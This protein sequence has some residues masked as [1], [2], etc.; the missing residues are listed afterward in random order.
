MG[1][2]PSDEMMT[3]LEK[4]C[5]CPPSHAKR[6]VDIMIALRTQRS[7]CNLFLGENSFITPRDLLR[8]AERE[9]SS[10]QELAE[11]GYM[12]LAERLRSEDEKELVQSI[13]ETNLKVKLN[14]NEKYYG[15]DSEARKLLTE[16]AQQLKQASNPL[17]ESIAATKTL[18]R[19]IS[20]VLRCINQKEPVLLV[21]GKYT[22]PYVGWT[23]FVF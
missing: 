6:L 14:M 3:I 18:L 1:D 15:S 4:R 23:S 16:A 7:K 19:L 2:I 22:I 20:L 13:L 12:L 17:V 5:A 21:G 8:W 10:K 9:S 11:Q